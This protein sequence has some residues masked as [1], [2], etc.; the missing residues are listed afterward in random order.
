MDLENFLQSDFGDQEIK[1]SSPDNDVM[2]EI[3]STLCSNPNGCGCGTLQL[4][5]EVCKIVSKRCENHNLGCINPVTPIGHCCKICGETYNDKKLHH[6]NDLR[7][8]L[9]GLVR[10]YLSV[11][12]Y[13]A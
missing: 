4:A 11:I 12:H 2:I 7:I 10:T 5:D 6:V 8:I 9:K 13:S 3:T 1:S